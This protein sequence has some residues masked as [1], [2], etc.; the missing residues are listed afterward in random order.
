MLGG[1]FQRAQARTR[2]GAR[3]EVVIGC[4]DGGAGG[5]IHQSEFHRTAGAAI[6]ETYQFALLREVA[7]PPCQQGQQHRTEIAPEIG[8]QVF[9]AGRMG[10]V[11]APGQQPVVHQTVQSSRQHVRRDAKH[12]WNSSKRVVP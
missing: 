6:H 9:V 7:A 2:G 3:C 4:G 5:R 11:L 10:A 8:Q 1:A 12:F